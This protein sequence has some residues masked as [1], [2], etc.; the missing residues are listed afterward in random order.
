MTRNIQHSMVDMDIT[1]RINLKR[2]EELKFLNFQFFSVGVSMFCV[3]LFL[4]YMSI[5]YHHHIRM[6]QVSN[7]IMWREFASDEW[8]EEDENWKRLKFHF[9]WKNIL[10]RKTFWMNFKKFPTLLKIIDFLVDALRQPHKLRIQHEI[11]SLFYH[12][13]LNVGYL[14]EGFS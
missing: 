3:Y 5:R 10:L 8:D 11:T 4:L 1:R 14:A 6:F 13:Y 12:L 2:D 9:M 7:V